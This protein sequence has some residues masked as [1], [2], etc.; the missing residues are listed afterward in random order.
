MGDAG[1]PSFWD[2]H[3]GP[4][5]NILLSHQRYIKFCCSRS[6]RLGIDEG[7][8]KLGAPPPWDR[9]SLTTTL[10][11]AVCM[12]YLTKFGHSRF[13]RL[14]IGRGSKFILRMLDLGLKL[15]VV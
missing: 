2:G 4:F 3:G 8:K 10:Y 7:P 1:A 15:M 13:N 5:R 12:Y 9:A 14:S 6:N 11:S